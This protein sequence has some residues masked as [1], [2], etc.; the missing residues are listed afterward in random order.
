MSATL[1]DTAATTYSAWFAT[2]ADPTRVKVLH[3]VA[4]HPGGLA[5]GALA[6]AVGI[7]QPTASHHVRL[8]ADAGF[9][10]VEKVGTSSIVRIDEGCC[11][12][13]PHAA[14]AVM[15]ALDT[16][17]CCAD[18]VPDD[19]AVRPLRAAD[20]ARV[21]AVYAEGIATGHATFSTDPAE[22]DGF[23][24]RWLPDHRL[25]AEVGGE[26]A[27]WAALLPVSDRAC[28]AGVAETQ[29]Y[30]GEAFRG[31]RVGV[32]LLDA[33]VRGADDAGLWTLQAAVFTENTASIRL[34]R[35]MGFRTVGV[36]ERIGRLGGEWRDTVLL[37]RRR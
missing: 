12:G 9:V 18:D 24:D 2:L 10:S 34:H 5:V 3:A 7:A 25:A 37:E 6:E 17:P 27:G 31:R 35:S 21:R 23:W 36:R 20:A 16:L 28:Y 4:T 11:T 29:V 33:L 30:V 22:A 26:V 1:D 8:L 13:L 32:A 19:V 14:D 15:G